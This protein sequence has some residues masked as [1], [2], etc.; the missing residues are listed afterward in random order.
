MIKILIVEDEKLIRKGLIHTVDW[1]SMDC[2]VV[3]EAE[4]GKIGLEQ[5]EKLK[6]DLVITDIRM[7][8]MDGLEMLKKVKSRD[9]FQSIIISSY[10]DFEYAQQALKLNAF[11][12][13]LKPIDEDK[14][15][16]MIFKVSDCI[17]DKKKF[18][19][20]KSKL[21]N[22]ENINIIDIE[23]YQNDDSI[24]SKY[25]NEIIEYIV[26]HYKK[27]ISIDDISKKLKVSASYLSRKFKEDTQHTFI[28]FLNKYR[29]QKSIEL[30]IT[31]EYKI[32]EAA[33]LVGFGDY[34]YFSHVFKLNMKCSPQE[35]IKSDYYI[36][37]FSK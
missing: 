21:K 36:S 31:G 12:Y 8:I 7:P 28:D 33:D 22:V 19:D 37:H 27:K 17:E 6:P 30:L 23:C 15:R 34:K 26:K 11:D 1:L 16:N 35:F 13:L 18:I 10:A 2:V 9:A 4:N 32:Y 5:I 25:S 20:F 29:I 3:G 24:K 14:L